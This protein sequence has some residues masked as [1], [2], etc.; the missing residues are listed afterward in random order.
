M[1]P[2]LTHP[3][4]IYYEKQFHPL[5]NSVMSRL[6][7]QWKSFFPRSKYTLVYFPR[8]WDRVP[9]GHPQMSE[10]F[11][12]Y[13][14]EYRMESLENLAGARRT[15]SSPH[16]MQ[17]LYRGLNEILDR[18]DL[19]EAGFIL[20]GREGIILVKD[21]TNKEKEAL[22]QE[23]P[24][25]FLESQ[26]LI[27]LSKM[28]QSEPYSNFTEL[29]AAE[30][31]MSYCKT[32]PEE[33][34]PDPEEEFER[35]SE[36]VDLEIREEL[37]L[38]LGG[39]NPAVVL[40]LLVHILEHV[41]QENPVMA[42]EIEHLLRKQM[43]LSNRPLS[44]LQLKTTHGGYD[45]KIILADYDMEIEMPKL[46]KALYLLFLRH[47][48]GIYLHDLQDYRKELLEIYR[49]IASISDQKMLEDNIARLVNMTDNSVHVNCARIKSAFAA[50]IDE[51]FAMHYC[52][53]GK[54][55]ERKKVDL[56]PELI[57]ID[58]LLL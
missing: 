43:E 52:V 27:L 41:K 32:R 29:L 45:Y 28:L 30:P 13:Q 31:V 16:F 17:A 35:E 5:L 15:L 22:T 6:S 18:N 37:E 55:G 36:R 2:L 34:F 1:L 4:I 12:Y 24:L 19:P 9:W 44:V 51:R 48:E 3:V 25:R 56:P 49:K 46:P 8:F 10:Q 57:Q 53:W 11:R 26:L 23:D 50:K 38:K 58:P 47:P 33:E 21:V 42:M 40:N 7:D 39:E 14:P 54:R 20:G